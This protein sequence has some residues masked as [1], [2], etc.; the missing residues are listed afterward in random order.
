MPDAKDR[1]N[2]WEKAFGNKIDLDH[3][4]KLSDIAKKYE[5]SGGSGI[6]ILK[7][8]VTKAAQTGSEINNEILEEAINNELVKDGKTN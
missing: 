8:C 4:I 5:I 2:L 1:L 7:Y 6:N 3:E